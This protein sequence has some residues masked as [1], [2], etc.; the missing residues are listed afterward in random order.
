MDNVST[1]SDFLQTIGARYRV[2]DIGRRTL[3]LNNSLFAQIENARTVAPHPIARSI[4]VGIVFWLKENTTDRSVWFL[5]FPLDETGL[6]SQVSRDEFLRELL[7]QS[8]N[9]GDDENS[10]GTASNESRFA[11]KPNEHSL[12]IFNARANKDLGLPP[13]RHYDHALDYLAGNPGYEQWAF[14]GIQGLADVCVRVGTHE[15]LIRKAVNK[16]PDTPLI[17][18]ASCLDS[19]SISGKLTAAMH[20]RLK[21]EI[22][23]SAPSSDVIAALVR[24]CAGSRAKRRLAFLIRD[25]LKSGHGGVEL[26]AAISGRCWPA[27]HD[28]YLCSLFLECVAATD[29]IDVFNALISDLMFVPGMREPLLMAFRNP[30]RS[31]LVGKAI[32]G[33]FNSLNPRRSGAD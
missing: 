15:E 16:L 29:D 31:E 20:S 24:A 27:L 28:D 4:C 25:A 2:Y 17:T 8:E 11:L 14:V 6:L 22:A 33:F 1:I 30:E 10:V 19:E 12:A 32:G 3:K 9:V 7:L 26:L 21:E 23:K 5:R 18:L 13:S